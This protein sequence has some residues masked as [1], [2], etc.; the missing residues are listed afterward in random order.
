MTFGSVLFCSFNETARSHMQ[1]A[2]IALFYI[3]IA[4]TFVTQIMMLCCRDLARG[5][6]SGYLLLLVFTMAET[7]FV[8]F[9]TVLFDPQTVCV[10]MGLT[11]ALTVSLSIYSCF[12]KHDLT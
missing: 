7:Y 8:T 9:F 3:A 12:T 1:G 11:A 2:P 4:I 5:F 6:P 10:A